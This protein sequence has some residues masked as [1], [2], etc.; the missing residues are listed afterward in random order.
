MDIHWVSAQPT[1]MFQALCWRSG[2][3]WQVEAGRMG[4]SLTQH[5]LEPPHCSWHAY[6]TGG[7]V[8][9]S[10]WHPALL[11]ACSAGLL[12]WCSSRCEA[13]APVC[14][15]GSP[16]PL[17]SEGLALFSALLLPESVWQGE[18]WSGIKWWQLGCTLE[19]ERKELDPF[20]AWSD[21]A[22]N[23]PNSSYFTSVRVESERMVWLV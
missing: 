3:S 5:Y 12:A 8:R 17:S 18:M 16:L 4:H 11:P 7:S 22:W 2:P 14:W 15:E 21:G 1:G 9:L 23:A 6:F 20:T 13:E 10:A 19:A